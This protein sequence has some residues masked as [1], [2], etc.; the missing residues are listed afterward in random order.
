MGVERSPF[1]SPRCTL[2]CMCRMETQLLSRHLRFSRVVSSPMSPVSGAGDPRNR[3]PSAGL[4]SHRPGRSELTACRGSVW[5][6]LLFEALCPS[7]PLPSSFQPFVCSPFQ[8]PTVCT[9]RGSGPCGAPTTRQL[10]LQELGLEH[11]LLVTHLC[12]IFGVSCLESSSCV[13]FH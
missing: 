2:L 6:T 10:L 1:L 7:S 8:T 13:I 12:T 4:V 3:S 9:G 5:E 11:L